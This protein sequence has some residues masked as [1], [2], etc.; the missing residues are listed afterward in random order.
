ML[1]AQPLSAAGRA[2][3]G[4]DDEAAQLSAEV[5]ALA[6]QDAASDSELSAA[7]T[8]AGLG[9]DRMDAVIDAAVADVSALGAST[10][11]PE[12]RRALVEAITRRLEETKST[13][14]ESD[15]DAGTRAASASTSAAGY[16]GIGAPVTPAGIGAP[17]PM[18][19]PAMPAMPSMPMPSGMGMPMMGGGGIPMAPFTNL[20][21]MLATPGSAAMGSAGQLSNGVMKA[22]AAVPSGALGPGK[23]SEKGLQ[24]Y[25]I[26]MNRAISAAFP[27]VAEIGGV[28]DD[29]LHWHPDGLALDVMIPNP[30]SPQGIALGNRV[31]DF[32]LQNKEKLH[33]D[34]VIWRQH[35]YGA[36]GSVRKMED[37]GSLT[38][39]HFDHVHAVSEGGGYPTGGEV[40]SL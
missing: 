25:T 31:V 37:R 16:S 19:A 32:L 27:E 23:A 26:L 21:S 22:A 33:V 18:G 12:G 17:A 13:L 36:D 34:H 30:T 6:D 14:H 29:S 35:I 9:R 8:A 4:F 40:Y 38:Q 39:N 2:A 11:T 1:P 15:S 24:R 3:D 7:I 28:R 5:S 10:D 20:A